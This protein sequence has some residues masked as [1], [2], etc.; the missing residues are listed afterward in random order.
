MQIRD[1]ASKLNVERAQ[2]SFYLGHNLEEMSKQFGFDN[3]A[4]FHSWMFS[5][6]FSYIPDEVAQYVQD[7][8]VSYEYPNG[9]PKAIK[10]LEQ[11]L[12]I[13]DLS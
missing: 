11:L 4:H 2:V 5:Q 8:F 10:A 9:N 7:N 12:G 1:L 13:N 3:A 6:G